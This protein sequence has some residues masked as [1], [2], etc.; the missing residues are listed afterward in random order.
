[1]SISKTLYEFEN[2]V[3]YKTIAIGLLCSA[4]FIQINRINSE[5]K[6][7]HF[8]K[9]NKYL[10]GENQLKAYTSK[11]EEKG[12]EYF[13]AAIVLVKNGYKKEGISYMQTG[14]ERSGKPSLGRILA[15]G[16]EKEN[17]F[18]QAERIYT[19]NKNAEPYRYEARMDLF[20]LYLK[21]TQIEKA[22]KMALEIINLPIKVPSTKI[23]Q[24]KNEAKDFLKK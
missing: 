9:E 7:Y 3:A 21:T 11:I 8:Y 19:Y 4:L 14:F 24:Y 6:L 18:D 22:K 15:N 10:K 5:N 12:E 23:T 13:M 16:L 17:N 2:N 20:H 1:M